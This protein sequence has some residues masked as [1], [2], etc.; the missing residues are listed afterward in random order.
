[1]I[2]PLAGLLSAVTLAAFALAQPSSHS[3]LAPPANGPRRADPTWIA[4]VDAAV[5]PRPGETLEHA[6]VILRDGR[7]TAVLPAEGD[8]PARL[9]LGPRVVDCKNLH[10][11]AAFVE[12]YAEIDAPAAKNAGTHWSPNVVPQRSA[13]DGIENLARVAEPLRKV[14]FGAAA[15]APRGG[16]FRGTSA[17][18]SLARPSEDPSADKP[19]VYLTHAYHALAFETRSEGYPDSQ[20][21]AIAL[22]RQTLLDADSQHKERASGAFTEARNALDALAPQP[23]APVPLLI[24][25]T[26][27]LEV[28]RAAKVAMEFSRPYLILGSGS[29]YR[30]LAAI[31]PLA[32]AVFVPV[33]FPKPPD[34]SSVG[35][36]EALD[37]RELM[38]WEQAP[39]NARRLSAAGVTFAFTSHRLK[40]KDDLLKNIRAAVK[41]GLA[42]DAAL[43]ALTTTPA[44]IL[45]LER[46]LG[47]IEAGKRANLLLTDAPLFSNPKKKDAKLLALFIDGTHHELAPFPAPELEGTWELTIA[48][49]PAAKRTLVFDGENAL[50]ITRDDKSVKGEKVEIQASRLAFTF[51]HEKLQEGTGVY[52]ISA[53]IE[54]DERGNPIGLLGQG[55]RHTGEAFD[56]SAVR[57]PPLAIVGVW[58]VVEPDAKPADK[59]DPK[60]RVVTIARDSVEV[61]AEGKPAKAK[62]VAV[63]DA[64]ATYTYAAGEITIK[65]SV[66]LEGDRLAGASTLP[67][68]TVRTFVCARKDSKDD[69]EDDDAD[70]KSIPE[71]LGLPFGPY[72]LAEPPPQRALLLTNATVWTQGPDATLVGAS[73]L[74]RNGVIE[75][76]FKSGVS[77]PTGVETIDCAG[78]HITPGIIDCH[79]HTGL[80]KGTNEAGQA[81]SS[82]VRV[83]DVTDPDDID[84]YRQLAGGVTCVNNLHGSANAIG[85]QSQTNKLR[86]GCV[87]P[88]AMHFEGAMP[89]IKFA[90]GENPRQANRDRPSS[91][92][93]QTRMGV[94]ML[95]RDRFT[96]AKEYAQSMAKGTARR[97]LE[98]EPLAEI[99]AGTRLLHC[100][101]YRQDEIVMLANV[102]KEYGFK[103]GT[104]QH[105]LEGYKVADYVRDYSGGGSAFADWWAYKV[106]VQDAI[107]QG[108]PLMHE[109]GAVVSYNSDSDELAR[110]LNVEAAKAVKY[111]GLSE[112][113]ALS[114]VTLNP[115]KQLR[116]ERFV[117]SLEPGKH[118]DLVIWSGHPLSAFSKAEATYIDG[119]C[120]FSLAQ[121]KLHRERHASDRQRILQKLLKSAKKK[122]DDKKPA[123]DKGGPEK[124]GDEKPT[125]ESPAGD[126]EENA[127]LRR[128]YLDEYNKGRDPTRHI[129]GR[130]GCGMLH[131][132][133]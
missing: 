57:L 93:P 124:S 1:M 24:D 8:R 120:Y 125:L 45:G 121:D 64:G 49:A 102:A 51:D 86:W 17:V 50:T 46:E 74:V 122:K 28:L 106:E 39:T 71:S 3:P 89:G 20:M 26:D 63:S 16:V 41:H 85:G 112:T 113:E 48:N 100:H 43:A 37:L 62:D 73:V 2:R 119:R 21:G 34:A 5:H 59:N 54:R 108:P 81:V 18:V 76:V 105:I 79:S 23:G 60:A 68:G 107:P 27:E 116:V 12:G 19:P 10:V 65:E 13:L 97:D 36:A 131:R 92:Y 7:I 129:Q 38:A 70:I 128:W 29:E 101:S 78:K 44:K 130:C 30:R 40:D 118:A 84:W 31:A 87:H 80:S 127:L 123:P 133:E 77:L 94:E 88:D 56:F 82:E 22:M 55:L 9:P 98:L 109:V 83:Q 67:D 33:N 111:G 6:T 117:G 61:A 11:Y 53:V 42:P 52:T 15:I 95:I 126:S 69:D 4:L 91:R 25:C 96:A 99:L 90:L 114:F 75:G 58:R 14:G 72:A 132:A 110:R 35:K 104:Y 47:T 66:K 32:P 115:A 103:I